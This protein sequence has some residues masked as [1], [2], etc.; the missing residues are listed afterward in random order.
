M[1]EADDALPS[2]DPTS[3]DDVT[4]ARLVLLLLAEGPG[5][6]PVQLFSGVD[7]F[8]HAAKTSA[9]TRAKPRPPPLPTSTL[10][11]L[12]LD[13]TPPARASGQRW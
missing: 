5:Q 7:G 12:P 4:G 10:C 13:Q 11:M 2:D 1:L 3:P 9:A 8:G 6:E